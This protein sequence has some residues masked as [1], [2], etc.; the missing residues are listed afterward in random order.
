MS[1]GTQLCKW[2]L[3]TLVNLLRYIPC[4][5]L[6]WWRNVDVTEIMPFTDEDQHF[7]IIFRKEK[8]YSSRKFICEF[9]NKNWSRH[10]LDHLKI[11]ESDS[12][13]RKSGSG[14]R[15]TASHDDNIDAVADLVQSQED[16]P[17]THRS[18]RQISRE[19]GIR[20]SY[21]HNIIKQDL[22]LNVWK[23]RLQKNWL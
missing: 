23:R 4:T 2:I 22:R 21:V 14:R 15:W 18:V 20:R 16:R 1:Y 13:A 19:T 3:I 10:D 17:Q 5:S 7:I 11:D 6:S 9:P 12:T 8:R